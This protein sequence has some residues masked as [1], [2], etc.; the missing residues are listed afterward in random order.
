MNISKSTP[1]VRYKENFS[2]TLHLGSIHVESEYL[3]RT[4]KT[5]LESIQGMTWHNK[6]VNENKELNLLSEHSLLLEG[7]THK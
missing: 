2:S 3:D 4:Q 6:V 7:E 1:Y 5:T